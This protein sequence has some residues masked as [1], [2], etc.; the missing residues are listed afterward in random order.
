MSRTET[1]FVQ[2][3]TIWIVIQLRHNWKGIWL[4]ENCFTWAFSCH[5]QPIEV[6]FALT[7]WVTFQL[8]FARQSFCLNKL[9]VLY[10]ICK[11]QFFIKRLTRVELLFPYFHIDE[12]VLRTSL[13]ALEL[14]NR[15]PLDEKICFYLVSYLSYSVFKHFK[16][17]DIYFSC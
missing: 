5:Y 13:N 3:L 4:I 17:S 15:G 2:V 7:N 12:R 9:W 14:A 10:K 16:K 8:R 6:D 11:K 1:E